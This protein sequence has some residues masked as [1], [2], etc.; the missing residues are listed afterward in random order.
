MLVDGAHVYRSSSA[1]LRI[2]RRLDFPYPLAWPLAYRW[3]VQRIGPHY[4]PEV[5]P[6][7][8]T[9]LLVRRTAD[10][11]VRFAA[12]S[13]LAFRLLELLAPGERS[14]RD[15]LHAQLHGLGEERVQPRDGARG[16][17]TLG[18]P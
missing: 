5:A 14:G 16:S 17:S 4:Q 15:C 18:P 11:E 7:A 12:L 3:P 6:D 13:P 10:G 8:P 9:L 1:A 2:A